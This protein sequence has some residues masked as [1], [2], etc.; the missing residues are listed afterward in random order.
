MKFL[1]IITVVSALSCLLFMPKTLAHSPLTPGDNESLATSTFI[2]DPTKSWA[3]Y[4]KLH[5]GGEAQY[6]RFNII[7]GQ[8]I[9]IMLFKSTNPEDR[10]FAPGFVLMG[11]S[12]MG[13]GVAP[14]YVEVPLGANTL[15]VEGRQP[16]HAT[17]EPFSPS[18][19]YSLA[20]LNLESPSSGTYYIAVYE[21]FKGGHYGLAIGDRESYTLTE[22]ILIPLNL[23][24]VYQWEGQSLAFILAPMIT[25][26]AI[27]IGMM[28]WLRKNRAT[29]RTL[30]NWLGS[31]AGLLFLGTSA[32]TLMQMVLSLIQAPLVSEIV[33]TVVLALIPIFLGFVT[34]R[35]SLRT[36]E[37][38]NLRM[39]IYLAI[40][41]V[42]ALFAWAGLFIGPTLAIMASVLPSR[43]FVEKS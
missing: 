11:L 5:E 30:F 17:Y 6:Y 3:I 41:G 22:W 25:T 36:E 39:R 1:G 10:D 24:F 31:L 23:I 35:L 32:I 7:E 8:R 20:D 13:Q 15:V 19:F 42:V 38:V 21:T 34:F 33:I 4:G 40:L 27:G 37:K 43:L 18:T 12:I 16:A 26:L 29:P 14:D 28:I 9:H 2:S